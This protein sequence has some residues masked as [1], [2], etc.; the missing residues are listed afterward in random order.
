MKF[1]TI[2]GLLAAICTTFALLPQLIKVW[3]SRHAHDISLGMY[4]IYISGIALWLIYGIIIN[5]LPVI[6]ANT[7]SMLFAGIILLFKIKYG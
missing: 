2:I 7:V 3:K 1:I 4:I 6:A 5:N